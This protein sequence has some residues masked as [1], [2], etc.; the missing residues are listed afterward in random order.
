[1]M[2]L[3]ILTT[4]MRIV[5]VD[6]DKGTRCLYPRMSLFFKKLDVIDDEWV[7]IIRAPG[8]L[9]LDDDHATG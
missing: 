9:R 1:M 4:I 3:M 2:I 7:G 8:A 6:D 5:G